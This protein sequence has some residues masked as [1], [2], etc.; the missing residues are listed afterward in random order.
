MRAV[1]CCAAYSAFSRTAP[2]AGGNVVRGVLWAPDGSCLLSA[3]EDCALRLFEL[4]ADACGA[5]M[6]SELET[7]LQIE[8]GESVYDYCWYPLMRSAEPLSCCVLSSCRDHPIRMWDAYDGSLRASYSAYNH[9]DELTTAYSLAFNPSGCKIYCGYVMPAPRH[10]GLQC[11]R[12]P[13]TSP[14][15]C[16]PAADCAD[17]GPTHHADSQ[18]EGRTAGHPLVLGVCTRWIGPVR[19]RFVCWIHRCLLGGLARARHPA[20]RPRWWH[21]AG[22]L[23]SLRAAH[24]DP[25]QRT[26]YDRRTPSCT[27]QVLWTH[28]GQ[29]LLTGARR[30][31]RILCWDVRKTCAPLCSYERLAPTNQR[32]GFDL[33]INS[34]TLVTGSQV[35]HMTTLRARCASYLRLGTDAQERACY[36]RRLPSSCAP[37]SGW[38]RARIQRLPA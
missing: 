8:Q 17:R 9:L 30:D 31:G 35:A 1:S 24:L 21:H 15:S 14:T 22:E 7:A 29:Y 37:H 27:S 2:P 28:D 34:E 5:P 10:S 25:V 11:A 6:A 18:G 13:H 20:R 23:S 38:R 12:L 4:P 36:R 32:I 3:S 26:Q 19:R 33:S 16:A